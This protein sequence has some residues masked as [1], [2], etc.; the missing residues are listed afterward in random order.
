MRT[1]HV[2]LWYNTL[3]FTLWPLKAA[4][5]VAPI[6]KFKI[7]VWAWLPEDGGQQPKREGEGVV[8]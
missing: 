8:S 2:V 5:G 3:S 1:K 7:W 6:F 4:S